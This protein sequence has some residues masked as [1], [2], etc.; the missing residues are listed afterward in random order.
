[1]KKLLVLDLDETLIYATEERVEEYDFSIGSYRVLK[2][3]YLET[4]LYFCD[5]YFE[6]GIWTSSTD[7]YAK[8]IVENIL[9]QDINISFLYSRERCIKEMD[10]DIYE[11]NYIKDLKKLKKKGYDLNHIIVVDDSPEK[12]KRNYG[13]LVKIEP[14]FGDKNDIELAKLEIYLRALKD[15]ENIRAVEKRAWRRGD[16]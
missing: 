8:E 16:E 15:V 5:K 11:M 12:L 3:P 4:F 14:F 13:N 1:M 9:P 6:L 2:R 10:F 7:S